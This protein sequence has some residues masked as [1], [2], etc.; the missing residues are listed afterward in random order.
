MSQQLFRIG[1]VA[2]LFGISVQTLRHYDDIGLLKPEEVNADT[3]YRYYSIAQFE[4]LNTIR[5]LRECG[6]PLK[7]IAGFFERKS[8]ERMVQAIGEQ[9]RALENQI[10]SLEAM[11]EKLA[12]RKARIENALHADLDTISLEEFGPRRFALLRTSITP[13]GHLDLELSLRKIHGWGG[14][15]LAFLGKVGVGF[16]L[17]HILE[18]DFERYDF[19]FIELDDV[20]QYPDEILETPPC[21]CLVTRFEGGH[22]QGSLRYEVLL[23][24]AKSRGLSPCGFSKEIILIDEGISSD[25]SRTI[26]EIQLP[27]CDAGV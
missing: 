27:V 14:K 6:M 23:D 10:A 18:H 13:R 25:P 12:L 9:E 7:Q 22:G 24:E 11:R 16:S 8:P 15:P 3:G 21:L 17:E 26:T 4:S 2:R 19:V 1:D 20:E 5:Y